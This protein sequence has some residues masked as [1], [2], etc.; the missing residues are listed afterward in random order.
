MFRRPWF[1]G[2]HGIGNGLFDKTHRLLRRKW[3]VAS[4]QVMGFTADS[5]YRMFSRL[6]FHPI[7][8]KNPCFLMAINFWLSREILDDLFFFLVKATGCNHP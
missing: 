2:G 1:E 8:V 3:S 4:A 5:E 7:L 6:S